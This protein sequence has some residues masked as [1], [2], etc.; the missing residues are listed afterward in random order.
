MAGHSLEVRAALLST[1]EVFDLAVDDSR[2][3]LKVPA[4]SECHEGFRRMRRAP[5]TAS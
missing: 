4:K 2:F 1:G 5:S 3:E